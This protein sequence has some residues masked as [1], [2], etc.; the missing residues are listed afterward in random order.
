MN[1]FPELLYLLRVT[2]LGRGTACRAPTMI[3]QL[4]DTM[5]VVRHDDKQISTNIR[6]MCRYCKPALLH[7]LSKIVQMHFAIHNFTKQTSSVLDTNRDVI[8]SCLRI[9]IIPQTNR[10]PTMSFTMS[11][12]G[13]LMQDETCPP[14]HSSGVNGHDMSCPYNVN[15]SFPC[16]DIGR[17]ANRP[18]IF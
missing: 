16:C 7:N 9:I 1:W 6:I 4:K 15:L 3:Y 5:Q 14:L 12:H 18:Y 2:Y 10:T 11:T 17:F 8:I 13:V